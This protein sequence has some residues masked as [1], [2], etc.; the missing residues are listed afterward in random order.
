MSRKV[1]EQPSFSGPQMI[2]EE[3]MAVLLWSQKGECDCPAAEY[4][5]K[6]GADMMKTQIKV[7]GK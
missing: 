4:F 1:V 7:K 5:R 6:L 2:P 3:F